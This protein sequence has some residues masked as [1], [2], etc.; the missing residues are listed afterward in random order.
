MY[1]THQHAHNLL[2]CSPPHP[3]SAAAITI[4]VSAI[5][6]AATAAAPAGVLAL[7][8]SFREHMALLAQIPGVSVAEVR[9]KEELAGVAGLIIPGADQ[10]GFRVVLLVSSWFAVDEMV[11]QLRRLVPR[12]SLQEWQASSS[13]VQV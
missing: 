4:S 2:A 1:S 10:D 3:P 13:Q 11:W 12:R 6:G 9:T 7:Q 8:G 5:L